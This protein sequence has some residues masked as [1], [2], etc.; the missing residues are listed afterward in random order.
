MDSDQTIGLEFKLPGL[1]ISVGQGVGYDHTTIQSAVGAVRSGD[2]IVVYQGTYDGDINL[3][4]KE[5]VKLVSALPEDPCFVATVII[6][7]G[8]SSRA[9]TFNHGEDANTLINGFTIINGSS[10]EGPGGAIYIDSNSSPTLA[11][12]IISNCS[13]ATDGG[14]IYVGPGS[15]P[16]LRKVMISNCSA[17]GDGGGIYISEDSEPDFIGCTITNCSASGGYG[18]AVY[19]ATGS[20]PLFIDSTFAENTAGY[21]GGGIYYAQDGNSTINGCTFT[22][23]TAGYAGGGI[24]Y[25]VRCISEVNDCTFTHNTAAE[26]GGGAILYSSDNL[27]LVIDSNFADNVANYGGALYF[28]PNCFGTIAHTVLVENDSNG[29]GGAIFLDRDNYIDFNDCDISYNTA[30]CGGGLY[31]FRCPESRIIRCEIKHNNAS[32]G[33]TVWYDYFERDPNDPNFPLDPLNPIDTS[34]PNFDPDDP[35]YI[36]NRREA[37]SDIAQGGGIYSWVGPRLIKDTEI[38]YNTAR[39][40]GGGLYLTS[41]EDPGSTIGPELN[42]CLIANNKAG[43]DGGGISCNWWLEAIISNCTIVN[44]EI[45]G[46]LGLGYGGGLYCSH[47]SYV[48]VIN[49]IIWGNVSTYEGSQI[50]VG[51]GDW[52]APGAG[53]ERN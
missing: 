49:S 40:S 2:R 28:D 15:S 33:V 46:G 5:D 36:K 13:A 39:M 6:D 43:R 3:D 34:D 16:S 44:N 31:C 14:A 51:S 25:D 50:A 11:N 53:A 47:E 29:N 48:E 1:V 32:G 27:I 20:W 17:S 52:A 42:N 7:C 30:A 23:N 10:L 22:G 41:D 8:G 37:H 19:C 24:A 4:G 38:C 35:N 9:F 18:G 21:D 26:D 45:I 12:L